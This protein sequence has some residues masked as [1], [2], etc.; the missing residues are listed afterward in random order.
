MYRSISTSALLAVLLVACGDDDDA[1]ADGATNGAATVAADAESPAFALVRGQDTLLIEQYT[2]EGNRVSGTLRDP[3]G[4]RVEYETVHDL[5]GGESSMR[6]VMH[7]SRA[8]AGPAIISTFTVRGDSAFLQT[9][10]GD[11]TINSAD[12]ITSGALPYMSPS[13]GMLALVAHSARELVGDSGQVTLLAASV[14]QAPM[15][16]TPQVYW[17]ADTAWVIGS[18]LNRFR[19]VFS[20]GRLLSAEAPALQMRAVRLPAGAPLSPAAQPAA[21]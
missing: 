16:V 7:A 13:M 4:S 3:I 1:P 2:L 11:S 21:E 12:A 10:R 20:G 9:S 17:R 6:V 5:G 18:D 19:L 14:S 15:V 8:D